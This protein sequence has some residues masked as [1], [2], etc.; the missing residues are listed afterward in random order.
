MVNAP[1]V[2]LELLARLPLPWPLAVLLVLAVVASAWPLGRLARERV[3]VAAGGR[4]PPPSAALWLG[5]G[6]AALGLAGM[7]GTMPG[8][9]AIVWAGALSAGW[10]DPEAPEGPAAAVGMV[11]G[12]VAGELWALLYAIAGGVATARLG[13]ALRWWALAVFAAAGAVVLSVGWEI[14]LQAVRG[15]VEPQA[16]A[17]L[18]TAPQPAPVALFNLA[19]V[20][21][22]G[23]VVEELIFR[24]ALYELVR[25]GFGV[26]AAVLVS[27]VSFGLFHMDSPWVVVPLTIFGL[28]LGGLRAASGSVGPS[29]FAHVLNN[30]FAVVLMSWAG[31]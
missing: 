23:P 6:A 9:T 27:G 7:L 26:R 25:R 8:V 30:V 13:A 28:W 22:L 3:A 14:L 21:V 17:A 20:M 12:T 31:G 15:P 10:M 29:I 1:P 19:F 24:G 11:T 2:V 16:A 18:V 4:T 5:G